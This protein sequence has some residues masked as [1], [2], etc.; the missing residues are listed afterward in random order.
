MK[1]AV[2]VVVVTI[3]ALSASGCCC[4]CLPGEDA[5]R[6]VATSIN[7]GA[8]QRET[9]QVS[10]DDVTEAKVTV[11]FAGGTLGVKA[12]G[13]ELLDGEFIYN[14]DDLEP[15]IEYET[16]RDRGEL[17]VRHQADRIRWDPSVEVRNEWRLQFG[18]RVPLDMSFDVGASNGTLD[19]GGLKLTGLTLT[20]G[21]ADMTVRF[22]EPNPEH[23]TTLYVHSGAAKLSLQYLGNAN[24]SDLQFDGGLGT[25]TLDFRGEWQRSAKAHILAG[26]SQVVL[27]VPRDIGVR[28]CPGDVRRGDYDGLAERGDCYVN[29]LYDQ[30]DIQLDID[31]DLGLGQLQ[32]KQVN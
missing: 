31:L 18:Q 20:A 29:E 4:F 17:L 28:V 9:H 3:T 10:L 5:S 25:Y 19:L 2:W 16:I 26:A 6:R 24:L 27:R 22:N 21:T 11:Q 30:A 23:L 8:V 12:G 15:L 1:R 7:A 13:D 14:L 32:V